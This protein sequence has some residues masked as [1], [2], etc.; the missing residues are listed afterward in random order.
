MT[1]ISSTSL[2]DIIATYTQE[3]VS[4]ARLEVL[5]LP[6]DGQTQINPGE[7]FRIILRA[8]NDPDFS[9]PTGAD[10]AGVRLVNVRWHVGIIGSAALCNFIVPDRP[11]DSREGPSEDLPLLTPGDHVGDMYIFPRFGKSVL[12][13]GE[14]NEIELRGLALG[15]VGTFTLIFD[16][17]ADVDAERLNLEGQTSFSD[18][19]SAQVVT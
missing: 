3:Y 18:T 4:R 13:P 16:I 12:D 14:T 9:N 5:A 17:T 6:L 19:G 8:T 15:P 2:R 11:L 10:P 1:V 7:E